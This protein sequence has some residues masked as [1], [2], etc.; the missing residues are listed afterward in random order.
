M[1]S[2]PADILRRA[3]REARRWVADHDASVR[4]LEVA[5]NLASWNAATLGSEE[6]LRRSAEAR[7][8]L[9]KWYADPVRAERVRSLLAT[10]SSE[11]DPLLHRELQLLDLLFLEHR[12][13]PEAIEELTARESALET[14]FYTFRPEFEGRPASNNDLVEVLRTERDGE[15]RRAA[16]EA[17]KRIGAEVAGPL[18]EL[19]GRRNAAAREHGFTDYYSMRL[20]LD[21][22]DEV[23]LFALLDDFRS[24]SDGPFRVV[25][26]EIDERL[27]ARFGIS[28]DQLY[29]WHW[30]DFFAQEA[31]SVGGL[32]LDAMMRGRD[33]QEIA[34]RYFADIGLPIEDVLARSDLYERPGKDQHAFCTDLD[35]EGDVRVLCNLRDDER[36]MGTLLHE[37]GHAAYDKFIPRSLPFT[38][39]R[40]GHTL[41]TEA[42]AMYFGRLTR[43]P[44]WLRAY[45]GAAP[46]P[47]EIAEIRARLSASMLVSARWI[48]VMVHFERA[49]YR[50]PERTDLD[51]FWWDL[52][53]SIQLVRRPPGR[54]EPDWAAKIHLSLAPAYYHNYLLGEFAA[55]QLSAAIRRERESTSGAPGEAAGTFLRERLFRKG[56]SVE[57]NHLLREATGEELSSRFFVADFVSDREAG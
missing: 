7:V 29:P 28:T 15:R 49:L 16:W 27:A 50:D 54:R 26:S 34:R 19:A 24:R 31:P 1:S 4:P 43:D 42:V 13:S 36:W 37:L 45:A 32:D 48:L 55:S 40:A 5:A 20:E 3:D 10:S 17:S 30:D 33:L 14:T 11:A 12:L 56:A 52:V 51:T 22:I 9:R 53:E 18:R 46:S 38:L 44:D 8:A 23:E 47:E 35:R 41:L 21:E 57:W 2:L 39:R 6:E 25:R